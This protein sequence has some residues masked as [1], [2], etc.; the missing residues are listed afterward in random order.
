MKHI[1]LSA[2]IFLAG[3]SF[4]YLNPQ[5]SVTSLTI[6]HWNDFHAQNLP[7]KVTKKTDAGTDTSYLVG[8]TATLLGYID[9]L[10]RDRMSVAVMN[11]G[12][13]FQGTPISTISAGRSQVELMNIISPDAV[14]LGNHEFD[15]GIDSL[16]A[17]ISRASYSIVCANVLDDSASATLVPAYTVL[18]V[19]EAKLG[20]VGLTAPDLGLLT[21]KNNL[22]GL[23]LR[24]VDH[25]LD[26][27]VHELKL[28]HQPDIIIL[29]SHMGFESDTALAARR[30]DI[31]II[32]GGHSH[33]TLFSPV[34]KNQTIIVQAGSRGRYLGKLDLLLDLAG[35]SVKSYRGQLIETMVGGVTPDPVAAAKVE[36]L[37]SMVDKT[38]DE[39]IG[40]LA[41][42]WDRRAN[43]K[44]ES[45]IGNWQCD[46]MQRA[47]NTDIAFQNSAGIRK[48]LDAGPIKV[49]DVW[50]IN[51]FGNTLIKFAV[52]GDT[53]RKMIEWQAGI[54]TREFLQV[55]G[56]RYLYD[57]SKP[58]GQEVLSIEV[59]GKPVNDS[60]LYSISTNNY[61]SGHLYDFFGIGEA[62]VRMEDTGMLDREVFIQA[63]RDRETISSRIEGRIVDINK[64]PSD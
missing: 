11:A 49:R 16:R 33:T 51:P 4:S 52:Q 20:I 26:D 18:S 17:N 1:L 29:L 40:M 45:N 55:S 42:P 48:N 59:A 58:K 8:G 63:V 31:D 15:Y 2:L 14:T 34:K 62:S 28:K 23:S 50:E 47:T 61:V 24:S 3:N 35:D 36:E 12:D 21:I 10:R 27:A 57:S 5:S 25:T 39:V 32:V 53:L 37:E 9:S 30:D 44:K 38:L 43:Q 7:F 13:D 19:G 46:I 6:L 41:A 60:A 56:L 22:R 54:E 64:T